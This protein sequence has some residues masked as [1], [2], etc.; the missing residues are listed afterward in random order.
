[1]EKL[2]FCYN[3]LPEVVLHLPGVA[4]HELLLLGPERRVAPRA[5]LVEPVPPHRVVVRDARVVPREPLRD[6]RVPVVMMQKGV[7][8]EYIKPI[9]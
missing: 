1:M 3:H 2:I 8:L 6:A 9:Q 4:D 7:N 5:V